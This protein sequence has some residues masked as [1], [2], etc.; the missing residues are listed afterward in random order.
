MLKT[1]RITSLLA[2]LAAA[3][4]VA[5]ILVIGLKGNPEIKTVLESP[6]IIASIRKKISAEDTKQDT[7]SPLVV[8]AQ[9]FALRID[10]PPPPKPPVVEKPEVKK[11]PKEVARVATPKPKPP[12]PKK[13]VK[14]N[15]KFDLLATVVYETAPEKSLALLK[16][17]NLQEWFR[18]GEKAGGLDIQEIRDGSVVFTQS[19]RNPQ[20]QFVPKKTHPKSLLKNDAAST[21]TKPSVK[22]G[23]ASADQAEPIQTPDQSKRAQVRLPAAR[24][25]QTENGSDKTSA[26]ESTIRPM[27]RTSRTRQNISERIQ[28]IR[29]KPT[30]PPPAERKASIESTMSGIED[31]ISRQDESLSEEERQREKELWDRLL[32]SLTEEK[33]RLESAAESE[34]PDKNTEGSS[35][36]ESDDPNGKE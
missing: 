14:V 25:L 9:K 21:S 36:P 20:E 26:S 28:R 16:T 29:S 1:L 27:D 31:I 4:G 23:T 12:A 19:G 8:Q 13:K 15:T 32:K 34:V 7:L 18:V 3:S 30:P 10:P 11:P 24:Q 17:G 6:D 2:M 33:E 22:T 35:R 5:V